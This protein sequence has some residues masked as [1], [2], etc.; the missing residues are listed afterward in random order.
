MHA[1]F[2]RF[3]LIPSCK[4]SSGTSAQLDLR[5]DAA[6]YGYSILHFPPGFK[7]HFPQ[8]TGKI[9]WEKLPLQLRA[10]L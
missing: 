6:R 10:G 2:T 5:R 4:K 7:G 9:L 3:I 8:K 1:A